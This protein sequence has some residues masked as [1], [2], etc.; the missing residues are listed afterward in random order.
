[1]ESLNIIPWQVGVA[2]RVVL[3]AVALEDPGGKSEGSPPAKPKLDLTVPSRPGLQAAATNAR[4]LAYKIETTLCRQAAWKLDPAAAVENV[5]SPQECYV[6]PPSEDLNPWCS[7]KGSE[8]D[9]FLSSPSRWLE[10]GGAQ[11]TY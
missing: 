1:M 4:V 7:G 2:G 8:P 11:R 5:S 3:G 6:I 9:C 10:F